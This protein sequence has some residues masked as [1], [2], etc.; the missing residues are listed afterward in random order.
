MGFFLASQRMFFDGNEG[1]DKNTLQNKNSSS[2]VK[3]CSAVF[4]PIPGKNKLK[5]QL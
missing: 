4:W 3:K 5:N 1:E 2:T